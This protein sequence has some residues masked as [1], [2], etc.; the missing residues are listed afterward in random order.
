MAYGLFEH[1]AADDSDERIARRQ[2]T[3]VALKRVND[4]YGA[5]LAAAKTSSERTARLDLVREE[6]REVISATCDEYGGDPES[7]E[8]GILS[9]LATNPFADDEDDDSDDDDSED[10]KD[11]KPPWLK[12]KDSSHRTAADNFSI[13]EWGDPDVGPRPGSEHAE[14]LD[15]P[16]SI[17]IEPDW[18]GMRRWVEVLKQTQ[19]DVAAEIE[20]AMGNE[21]PGAQTP[22]DLSGDPRFTSK[23]ASGSR[24]AAGDPFGFSQAIDTDRVNSLSPDE[25]DQASHA[26][27]NIE[28]P[29]YYCHG[30][31]ADDP[32]TGDGICVA[33]KGT[34]KGPDGW[35]HLQ[36]ARD[37]G[38]EDDNDRAINPIASVKEA[39]RPKMCPYHREVTDISLAAGDPAAGFNAMASHAWGDN[40]CQG[41]FE[42]SC[43]FKR[44]MVTQSYWDEKAQQAQERR[45]QREL[46]RQQ[47]ISEPVAEDVV[48]DSP[49]GLED[50]PAIDE[51]GIN[52]ELAEAPSAIGE[53]VSDAPAEQT[54]EPM[55]ASTREAVWPQT[56]VQQGI[57]QGVVPP[58]AAPTGGGWPAQ[59]INQ[60]IQ[61]PPA[62]PPTA[63]VPAGPPLAGGLGHPGQTTTAPADLSMQ[64]MQHRNQQNINQQFPADNNGE[65]TTWQEGSGPG[66]YNQNHY[67][68]IELDKGFKPGKGAAVHEADLGLAQDYY[69]CRECDGTGKK[70]GEKCPACGGSGTAKNASTHQAVSQTPA[71][72]NPDDF[73]QCP[74]CG[75]RGSH[76]AQSLSG[77]IDICDHC[78]NDWPAGQ[79]QDPWGAVKHQ[80]AHPD[81][82][83]P[84]WTASYRRGEA[85]KTV[86]V[87]QGGET[88]SPEMDKG[89]WDPTNRGEAGKPIK[90]EQEGSPKPTQT[91]DPLKP[92]PADRDADF[93]EGT[94]AVTE[95]QDVEQASK[96]DGDKADSGSW[97]GNNGTTPVTSSLDDPDK[98]PLRTIMQEQADG[99]LSPVQ[100]QAAIRDYKQG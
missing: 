69:K 20:Q 66:A 38:L 9:R 2:A 44:E 53:G 70:D 97:A 87:T 73:Q 45:E 89:K 17:N 25:L 19:P 93:L 43:N 1:L 78:G 32:D 81:Y 35:E 80:P 82:Q 62:A 30:T 40:H 47:E 99:F 92:I 68:G 5:Y 4:R 39:R 72:A 13:P 88:P 60:A 98:N 75:Q 56:P 100:V 77:P 18:E 63:D 61:A 21:A 28:G 34:G 41:G 76:R 84:D 3:A 31:G 10:S 36:Q 65:G 42:G 48:P 83:G 54:L 24:S 29:C 52:S 33:C 49:E 67:R 79:Q 94:K 86:D 11:S 8:V 85:L 55:A 16:E 27:R 95:Q 46:Q 37:Q 59:P 74:N 71:Q 58:A 14:V 57:A 51:G 6:V 15:E 26:L 22:P 12:K 91:I 90:T 7:I 96:F 64:Q 23:T 50:T